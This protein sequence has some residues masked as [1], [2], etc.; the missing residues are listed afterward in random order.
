VE[1]PDIRATSKIVVATALPSY[2]TRALRLTAGA[3]WL[4]G[5]HALYRDRPP[6]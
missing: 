5:L 4:L 6:E 3:T 2:F 1:T